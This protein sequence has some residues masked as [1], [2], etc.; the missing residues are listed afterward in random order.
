MNINE[1]EKEI[2]NEELWI[3]LKKTQRRL[4]QIFELLKNSLKNP[5]IF[6][7][8]ESFQMLISE[9]KTIT[10]QIAINY[11]VEKAPKVL[12]HFGYGLSVKWCS[13]RK[14]VLRK[15]VKSK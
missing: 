4:N 15:Y 14:M 9:N 8:T 7:D 2:K 10:S 6:F 1:Q 12:K 11:L 3:E 13:E 5:E